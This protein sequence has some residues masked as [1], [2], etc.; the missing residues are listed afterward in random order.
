[1]Q[2]R[3][4]TYIAAA[5]WRWVF[6][7]AGVLAAV[8]LVPY[9]WALAANASA[10][11]WQFMGILANP[12]DGA[13]YLAKIGQGMRGEWL[14]HFMHTPEHHTG[15]AFFLL[16]SLLGHL[17][18]V[19][20][21]S[22]I[23]IFHVARVIATLFMFSALYYLGATIWVRQRPRRLFF[24]LVSISSGLGWLVLVLFPGITSVPDLV[25]PE[26]YPLYAAYANPHFPL[27]I[28]LLAVIAGSFLE[29]LAANPRQDPAL[30]N[31]GGTIFGLSFVLALVLP[32][33]IVPFAGALIVYWLV[34]FVR[35]RRF[36]VN[37]LHWMSMLFLPTGLL[38]FYYAVLITSNPALRDWNLQITN[39]TASPWLMLAAYGVPLI[40]A[41]PGIL[42]AI[43]KFEQGDQLM[44]I[45]LVVNFAAVFVPFNHQRRFMLG[46]IIPVAFFTVRAIEDF[47]I[48]WIPARWRNLAAVLLVAL[49]IPSN[50][51]ALGIP[52]FGLIDSQA[53]LEQK[54]LLEHDYWDAF[55]HLRS[56]GSSEEVVLAAPN[57]S[58]WIPAYAEKR[59]MYGHPYETLRAD[60][61]F[62]RVRD[63]YSGEDCQLP[64]DGRDGFHVR[65]VLFGPQEERFGAESGDA[66]ECLAV[67]E[68][69]AV[70]VEQFGEVTLYIV[71]N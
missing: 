32:Q 6:I 34:Q 71:G 43:R 51:L 49:V 26:A 14:V 1:M 41:I 68:S 2:S 62:A 63:W 12:Q 61:R 25:V 46:L 31:G 39:P 9:A 58:L 69:A 65:Y 40:V 53:G 54:L 52:L 7:V 48:D 20:G 11:D 67:V 59:V 35:L 23:V 29:A 56:L 10:G 42:R 21:V 64:T 13:T 28:G 33:A 16:Y 55:R 8:T 27:A 60:Q 4:N 30:G 19:I 37:D 70:D 15:A 36:P 18:R 47:W 38:A 57:P 22:N 17:A 45:W 24:I 44:L 3:E 66:S 5:E 50:V